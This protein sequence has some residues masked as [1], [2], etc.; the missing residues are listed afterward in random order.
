MELNFGPRG[1]LE[2]NDARIKFRNFSG[3]KDQY[4]KNGERNFHLIIPNQEIADTLLNDTNEYGVGWNVKIKAN[5]EEEGGAPYM[6]LPVKVNFNGRGPAVY[7]DVNGKRTRLDEDTVCM[8][9]SI[10][11][12]SV[13]LDITPYDGEGM[14]GPYRK[15]Y[16]KSIWVYQEVDRFAARYAE[17]EYPEE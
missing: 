3:R 14:Y 2:I 5:R 6:S 13:D 17:E 12:R 9:D 10:D 7:L 8:L 15:A 16:L 4:N 11:I 1:T